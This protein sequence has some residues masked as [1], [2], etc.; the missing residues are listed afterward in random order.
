[1]TTSSPSITAQMASLVSARAYP[2]RQ[3]DELPLGVQRFRFAF[4]CYHLTICH[5]PGSRLY[6]PDTLSRAPLSNLNFAAA[7]LNIEADAYLDVVLADLL[8]TLEK[9][10]KIKNAQTS[11]PDCHL[12]ATLP[13][14]KWLAQN[15]KYYSFAGEI[16]D[17]NSLLLN[18][19]FSHQLQKLCLLVIRLLQDLNSFS[20]HV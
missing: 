2:K 7:E 6:V 11:D 16:T 9:L 17:Q 1:M 3:I 10:K 8:A 5:I 4:T 12:I 13:R 14:E 18:D 19:Y 15:T 20:L